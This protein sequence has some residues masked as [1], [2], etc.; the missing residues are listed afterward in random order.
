MWFKVG[1]VGYE[2]G[3][4][5]RLGAEGVR[6]SRSDAYLVIR[7]RA[8]LGG[9]IRDLPEE[10]EALFIRCRVILDEINEL[11]Y[12]RC[13]RS[14]GRRQHGIELAQVCEDAGE[15]KWEGVEC[16]GIVCKEVERKNRRLRM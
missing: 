16:V 1:K 11:V 6:G 7:P 13:R 15:V 14:Y 5:A 8:Y 2:L 3:E 4:I 10:P 12:F 9:L